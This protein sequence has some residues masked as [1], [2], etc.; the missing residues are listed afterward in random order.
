MIPAPI[1][2]ITSFMERQI[3]SLSPRDRRLLFGLFTFGTF[4]AIVVLSWTLYGLLDDKASRVRTAR[5]NLQTA[6]LY[7]AEYLAAAEDLAA[8]E[9]RLREFE[10]KRLSAHLEE[11]A[12]KRGVTENLRSVNESS[13]EVVGNLKQTRYAV[14]LK[15]LEHVDAIGFLYEL[16]TSGYPVSVNQADFRAKKARDGAS[17]L[18]LSLELI[19]FSLA[20]G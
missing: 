3:E 15:D 2:R 13:S 9:S 5:D 4:V 16:E 1:Q 19:V 17:K 12:S 14:E 10:D 18:D 6:R 20:E 7:Q 11:L 8:Q